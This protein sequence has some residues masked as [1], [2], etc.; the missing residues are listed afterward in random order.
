MKVI[1][2]FFA[3][4]LSVMSLFSFAFAAELPFEE[5]TSMSNNPASTTTYEKATTEEF[6]QNTEK[7]N[8][9][10]TVTYNSDGT[11]N[12]MEDTS[13]CLHVLTY[14]C[15][16]E[17]VEYM[18]E[19]ISSFL[20]AAARDGN[21]T[22]AGSEIKVGQPFTYSEY[23]PNMFT[24]PVY[25]DNKIVYTY[26]VGRAPDEKI[27]GTL[28]KF[29]V[30]ELN[31]YLGDTSVTEPLHFYINEK[32]L[33]GAVG[34]DIK[35]LAT[36]HFYEEDSTESQQRT[37][38]GAELIVENVSD[39][40]EF[41]PSVKISRDPARYINLSITETQPK[42]NN[43]CVA[44]STAA[45]LRTQL[46]ISTSAKEIMAFYDYGENTD[47]ISMRTASSYARRAGLSSTLYSNTYLSDSKLMSEID[48]YS[49]VM[50]G[51]ASLDYKNLAHAVVLRGY[52]IGDSEWSIWDPL[53]SDY[54]YY[55]MEYYYISPSGYFWSY[56]R[57]GHT[58]YNYH[59]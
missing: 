11:A 19:N 46:K 49:P 38:K 17:I 48:S 16:T 26:R 53:F 20:R 7:A 39:Y 37:K 3:I 1:K 10:L 21:G 55:S 57:D 54:Q 33:C 9:E 5:E 8:N 44:Y 40:F 36:F 14:P 12:A 51:M 31:E 59:K 25:V 43:W 30:E 41:A 34:N 32:T 6:E 28:S 56:P 52:A 2:K 47:S 29:L 4:L 35:E 18:E 23:I 15:P 22:L 24:F 45:V 50:L 42:N 13:N 27:C 58:I